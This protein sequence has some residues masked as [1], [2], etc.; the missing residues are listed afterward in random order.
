[1]APQRPEQRHCSRQPQ[2]RFALAC[3]LEMVESGAEV[4][5]LALHAVE[6][7]PGLLAEIR[8]RLLREGQEVL[9]VA[10]PQLLGLARMLEPLDRILPDRLQH[11]KP[12]LRVAE[13]ALV[14]E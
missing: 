2:N 14:D 10:A 7:L 6:P 9:R 13:E 12:L 11:P 3:G 4:V 8:L 1:M 5:V